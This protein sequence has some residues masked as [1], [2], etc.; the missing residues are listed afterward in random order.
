M[1]LSIP[2]LNKNP[3]DEARQLVKQSVDLRDEMATKRSNVLGES[4]V[5]FAYTQP[6]SVNLCKIADLNVA[7]AS[8]IKSESWPVSDEISALQ[9][10]H[11]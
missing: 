8:A 11:K 1:H 4:F 2:I 7:L 3:F 5:R 10:Q 9:S 6:Q